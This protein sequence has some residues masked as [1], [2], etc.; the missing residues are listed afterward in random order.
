MD[1][2]VGYTIG[3]FIIFILLFTIWI[4]LKVGSDK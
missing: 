3:I 4:C 2:I 1:D